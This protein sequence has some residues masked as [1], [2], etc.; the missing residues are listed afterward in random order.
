MDQ[1]QKNLYNVVYMTCQHY[2]LF[3]LA[4]STFLM[5]LHSFQS[6][7]SFTVTI[8]MASKFFH[9]STGVV[10]LKT[11]IG[12]CHSFPESLSEFLC[13]YML[14]LAILRMVARLL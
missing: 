1:T 10:L 11:Q 12:L 3:T 13:G 5:A 9:T 8:K 2:L 4:S 7:L 6:S 14:H